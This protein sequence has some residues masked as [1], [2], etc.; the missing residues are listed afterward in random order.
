MFTLLCWEPASALNVVFGTERSL[1]LYETTTFLLHVYGVVSQSTNC[2]NLPLGLH[3]LFTSRPLSHTG[4]SQAAGK[5]HRILLYYAADA[6]PSAFNLL[7]YLVAPLVYLPQQTL[8]PP[9]SH[10][11]SSMIRGMGSSYKCALVLLLWEIAA[12]CMLQPSVVR[13]SCWY[14]S[15]LSRWDVF[16]LGRRSES[17]VWQRLWVT[18][19]NAACSSC[20]HRGSRTVYN[21]NKKC[22]S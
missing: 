8:P 6:H 4:T 7:E 22:S 14:P 13:V 19:Q 10:P 3:S 16:V 20:G 17:E 9:L 12:Q 11:G 21:H 15:L 5:I 1:S 18:E 2:S